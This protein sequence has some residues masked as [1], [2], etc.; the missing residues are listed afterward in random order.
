M[1]KQLSLRMVPTSTQPFVANRFGFEEMAT[2]VRDRAQ[3]ILDSSPP[4]E[5]RVK[6]IVVDGISVVVV[7]GTPHDRQLRARLAD[8][9]VYGDPIVLPR[10]S[11][12]KLQ[13]DEPDWFV[14]ARP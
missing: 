13:A 11:I 10:R 2:A 4:N 6:L 14:N 12:D 3:A 7:F 5:L 8:R 1:H 9:F